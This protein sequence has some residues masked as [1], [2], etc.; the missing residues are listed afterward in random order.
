[1]WTCGSWIGDTSSRTWVHQSGGASGFR[2]V[3]IS[4]P[5]KTLT[6]ADVRPS[7]NPRNPSPD[8][9][10]ACLRAGHPGFSPAPTRAGTGEMMAENPSPDHA[11]IA[12]SANEVRVL[13]PQVQIQTNR[14]VEH[15]P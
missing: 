7:P 11:S 14:T 4:A 3:H 6:D 9:Q 12:G 8:W 1:M 10:S 2:R 13:S 15:A 5:S